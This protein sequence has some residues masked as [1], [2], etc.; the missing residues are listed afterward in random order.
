MV[1]D[2][3]WWQV[4]EGGLARV[5]VRFARAE[6]R[7]TVRELP[8]G[9]L[10]PI[11]RKSGWWLAEQAGH[12]SPDRMQRLRRTAVWD[13]DAVATDLREFVVEHLGHRDGILVANE[14]GYLKKG[15]NAD[16]G[17][18][19]LLAKSSMPARARRR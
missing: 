13:T 8:L 1:D 5:G 6:P 19:A 15:I 16:I 10:A 3:V 17:I 12:A 11:E 4:F 18:D 14:T 9:L 7:R 2:T